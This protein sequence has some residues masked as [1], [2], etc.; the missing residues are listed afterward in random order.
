MI[1][2]LEYSKLLQDTCRIL[3]HQNEISN[4]KGEN[5]NIFSI[6]KMETKENATHSAFLGELLNPEGSH[7][8]GTVFLKLFLETIDYHHIDLES[9]K[10]KLEHYIGE[11]D[12]YA[13]IGGRIDVFIYDKNYNTL[14]IE[15]K[16]DAPD[17]NVQIERY[18]N[19]NSSKNTVYYLTKEG[20]EPDGDSRGELK[21]GE[22]YHNLS[23]SVDIINW[24]AS[25]QKEVSLYPILRESI[26]QYIILIKKMTDQLTDSKMENEIQQLIV[27]NY[28][29]TKILESNV[30]IVELKFT[31]RFLKEIKFELEKELIDNWEIEVYHDLSESWTGLYINHKD[32]PEKVYVKLEGQSKVPWNDSIYGIIGSNKVCNRELLNKELADIDLL[33]NGFKNNNNWPFYKTILHFSNTDA[34]ADLFNDIKRKELVVETFQKIL[35][36]CNS[37]LEPLKKVH[38]LNNTNKTVLN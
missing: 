26:N 15:N 5:F 22:H 25:C 32:W 29:S 27:S 36:L 9:A 10:L 21:S 17:Q 11:R 30:R 16:I 37:C 24:L 31:E 18:C 1:E 7:N 12:D 6:L 35:E 34:R 38:T 28:K 13:K 4:L 33:K 23:Y 3:E 2:T 8:M 14:C 19:Y 20:G